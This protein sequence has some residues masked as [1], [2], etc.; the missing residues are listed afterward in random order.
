MTLRSSGLVCID[1]ITEL[2]EVAQLDMLASLSGGGDVDD[3]S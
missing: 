1:D 2:T 3:T